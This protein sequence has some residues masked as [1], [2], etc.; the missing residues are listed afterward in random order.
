MDRNREHS[1]SHPSKKIKMPRKSFRLCQRNEYGTFSFGDRCLMLKTTSLYREKYNRTSLGL[2]LDNYNE[3]MR[4]GMLT[5]EAY[6]K[7][8][9]A[10]NSSLQIIR[11]SIQKY[12]E[13]RLQAGMFYLV[14]YTEGEGLETRTHLY[15]MPLKEALRK[16]RQEMKRR[17]QLLDA[18][19]NS[20]EYSNILDSMLRPSVKMLVMYTLSSIVL[21]CVILCF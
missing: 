6:T 5:W 15:H 4:R 8:H 7:H 19:D 2:A 12:K 9:L 1:K 16:R 21:G 17:K 18:S 11:N 14:P 10:I 20:K 3:L 13:R